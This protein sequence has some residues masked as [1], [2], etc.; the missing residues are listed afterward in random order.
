MQFVFLIMWLNCNK[1]LRLGCRKHVLALSST[2]LS[3]T[4]GPRQTEEEVRA[5]ISSDVNVCKEESVQRVHV[6]SMNDYAKV[7]V[8]VNAEKVMPTVS[9]ELAIEFLESIPFN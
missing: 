9:K 4:K 5:F 7:F 6:Y 3:S 2:F 8:S 1:I